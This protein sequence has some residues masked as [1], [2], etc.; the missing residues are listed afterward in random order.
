[1]Y[2]YCKNFIL[3]THGFVT[4]L[5]YRVLVKQHN[6]QN[7]DIENKVESRGPGGHKKKQ[8]GHFLIVNK[9]IIDI[10]RLLMWVIA[11][12][13]VMFLL[14]HFNKIA[15]FRENYYTCLYHIVG[16]NTAGILM[17]LHYVCMP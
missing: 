5:L 9:S 12:W 7:S 13:Q 4:N 10:L 1:M 3:D 8:K 6:I 17:I 2:K 11:I 15:H 16:R 14:V